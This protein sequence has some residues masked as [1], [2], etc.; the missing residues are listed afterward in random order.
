MFMLKIFDKIYAIVLLAEELRK[1]AGK[2]CW[3]HIST[4]STLRK[5][6]RYV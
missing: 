3:L 2:L 6:T 4:A 5:Q 1:N